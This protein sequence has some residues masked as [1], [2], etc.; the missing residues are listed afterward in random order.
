MWKR[1]EKIRAFFSYFGEMELRIPHSPSCKNKPVFDIVINI[2]GER[3]RD[4]GKEEQENEKDICR[5]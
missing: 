3:Y 1:S 4:I 2:K 5:P